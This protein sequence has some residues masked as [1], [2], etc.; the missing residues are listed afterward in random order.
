MKKAVSIIERLMPAFL[1]FFSVL[2]AGCASSGP[3]VAY[4]A[5]SRYLMLKEPVK[6]ELQP[7]GFSIT[8]PEGFVTDLSSTPE[9]FR[10]ALPS[11]GRRLAAFIIH[12]YMYW[13]QSCLRE[14]ADRMLDIALMAAKTDAQT[15][16]VIYTGAR[17]YGKEIWDA[18]ANEKKYGG[19]RVIPA[20]YVTEPSSHSW[21]QYYDSFTK[22]GI[23]D[24]DDQDLRG[25]CRGLK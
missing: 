13:N 24:M 1:L 23:Q 12:D 8:V 7:T 9:A 18:Y 15:R 21:A 19:M 10:K 22:M 20:R 6:F 3:S 16:R 17:A 14:E 2:S 25:L 4:F 11:S 5:D